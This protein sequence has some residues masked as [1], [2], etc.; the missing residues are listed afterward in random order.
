M[1]TWLKVLKLQNLQ[2]YFFTFSLYCPLSSPGHQSYLFLA[3]YC[4]KNLFSSVCHPSFRQ[5]I[6][7]WSFLTNSVLPIHLGPNLLTLKPGPGTGSVQDG[8]RFQAYVYAYLCAC[9]LKSVI[10]DLR[11][12][13]LVNKSITYLLLTCPVPQMTQRSTKNGPLSSENFSVW[14]G[15][16]N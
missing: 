1:F 5:V 14:L 16:Q 3:L 6:I 4:F 11:I 15:R 13:H 7:T 12:A 2:K 10:N 9:I 8:G